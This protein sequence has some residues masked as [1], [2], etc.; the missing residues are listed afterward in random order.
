MLQLT[1]VGR[2]GQDA[3]VRYTPSGKAVANFSLAVDNG[4]D[5]EGEKKSATWIKVEVWEKRAESLSPHITKGKMLAI[6]GPARAEA[7]IDK[8]GTAQARIVVTL[9]ELTFCGGGNKAADS[10]DEGGHYSNGGGSTQRPDWTPNTPP[11]NSE[12]TDDD[13]PF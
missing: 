6:S 7:W 9:R 5:R 8:Q 1:V 11:N 13:I 2:V 3:D 10:E 4:K 12:I